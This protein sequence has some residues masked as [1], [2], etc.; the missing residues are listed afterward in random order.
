MSLQEKD[1]AD[2]KLL[3]RIYLNSAKYYT[4]KWGS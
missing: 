3:S 4:W 1:G 2:E